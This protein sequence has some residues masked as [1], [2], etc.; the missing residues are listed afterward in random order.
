MRVTFDGFYGVPS[1]VSHP[2]TTR[3]RPLVATGWRPP[4][5]QPQPQMAPSLLDAASPFLLY[6]GGIER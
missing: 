3:H 2:A 6:G 1:S 4:S 5:S